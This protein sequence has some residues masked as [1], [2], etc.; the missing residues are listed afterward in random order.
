LTN[1][2][3]WVVSHV[4]RLEKSGGGGPPLGAIISGHQNDGAGELWAGVAHTP[5][6][7]IPG[8]AKGDICWYPY[9]GKEEL[10]HDFSWVVCN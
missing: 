3:S 6:G 10:T 2:F 5:H 1:D 9:A 8:K 4:W 7:D